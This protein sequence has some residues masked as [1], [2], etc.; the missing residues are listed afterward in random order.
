MTNQTTSFTCTRRDM[1]KMAGIGTLGSMFCDPRCSNSAEGIPVAVQL[2]SIR[3]D[4]Q[5]DFDAALRQVAEMGFAAVEFAGYHNYAGSPSELKKRLASLTLKVAGTHIRTDAL[6]PAAIQKT[7]DFHRE[8]GCSLLIV[9]SDPD[10][11]N[12]AKNEAFAETLNKAAEILKPHGMACGYHNHQAEMKKDGEKTFWEILAERTTR[13]VILQQDCGWTLAAGRDPVEFIQRYPGRSRTVHFKPTVLGGDADKKPVLG[14]DS[15]DW[16]AVYK[17][18]ASV[19][20]TEWIVVEQEKYLEGV[21]PMECTRR[22]LAGLKKLI[23]SI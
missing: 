13:D 6:R 4:C 20:G 9:P 5:K 8:I 19:G 15:V 21:F 22:S 18:C 10:A 11:N 3:A 17:A 12:P 23:A 16:A 2:Y 14:Q 1:L 7:I